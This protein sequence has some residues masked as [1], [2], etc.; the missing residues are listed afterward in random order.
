MG[1]MRRLGMILVSIGWLAPL[2]LAA[3]ME[4]RFLWDVLVPLAVNGKPWIGSFTPDVCVERL[5]LFAML[6]LA[7]VIAGWGWWLTGRMRPD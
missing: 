2:T 7:G 1:T 5:Y 4:H 6:W 3:W